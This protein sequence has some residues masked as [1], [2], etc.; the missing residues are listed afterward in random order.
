MVDPV[1][2][3]RFN[4]IITYWNGTIQV[5][6]CPQTV[7]IGGGF[8]FVDVFSLFNDCSSSKDGTSPQK[9]KLP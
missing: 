9:N 1:P 4:H 6:V 2:T 8:K 5:D 7:K 3:G